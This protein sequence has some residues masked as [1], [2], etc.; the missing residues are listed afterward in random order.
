MMSLSECSLVPWLP[1][2]WMQLRM[3]EEPVSFLTWHDVI[4]EDEYNARRSCGSFYFLSIAPSV[5]VFNYNYN[6]DSISRLGSYTAAEDLLSDTLMVSGIKWCSVINE[7]L[8]FHSIILFFISRLFWGFTCIIWYLKHN[9]TTL[10]LSGQHCYIHFLKGVSRIKPPSLQGVPVSLITYGL[11]IPSQTFVQDFRGAVGKWVAVKF[12]CFCFSLP[13]SFIPCLPFFPS[14]LSSQVSS[15]SVYYT[16]CKPKNK[17]RG[18]PGNEANSLPLLFHLPSSHSCFLPSSLLFLD[19]FPS[20]SFI[21]PSL[22][23]PSS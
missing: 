12:S 16:E 2:S 11:F 4:Y 1:R 15:A 13:F 23:F 5:G 19:F 3:R 22:T 6:I 9:I 8:Y 18:R 10:R 17:K 20:T 21:P 7:L 14:P